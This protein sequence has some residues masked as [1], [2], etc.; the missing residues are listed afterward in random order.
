MLETTFSHYHSRTKIPNNVKFV[1]KLFL[2]KIKK[3]Y[4]ANL[5]SC[6]ST[7]PRGI[8]PEILK[9]VTLLAESQSEMQGVIKFDRKMYF[10]R[11]RDEFCGGMKQPFF[12]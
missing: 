12:K 9:F 5:T 2:L 10:G 7:T 4:T 6:R 8:N 11:K 3:V 1:E